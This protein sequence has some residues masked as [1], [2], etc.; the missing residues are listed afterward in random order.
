MKNN[1]QSTRKG[2]KPPNSDAQPIS[3]SG[4]KDRR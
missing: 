3:L 2:A 1:P 4:V